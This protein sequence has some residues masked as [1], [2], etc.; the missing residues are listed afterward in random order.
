MNAW[1]TIAVGA[2]IGF[3]S[4]AFTSASALPF[5][6]K[7]F[8]DRMLWNDPAARLYMSVEFG[9][10]PVEHRYPVHLGLRL[11]RDI[12]ADWTQTTAMAQID[13]D[14]ARYIAHRKGRVLQRARDGAA[15][16]FSR[17]I[18][19]RRNLEN[20]LKGSEPIIGHSN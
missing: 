8:T 17:E 2:A 11:D 9:G 12:H 14:L 10:Q 3:G 7:G 19:H 20:L 16:S 5:G 4:T 6:E 1:K 15:Y 18:R 13:F